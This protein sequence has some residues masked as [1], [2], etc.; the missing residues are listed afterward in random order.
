LIEFFQKMKL[1]PRAPRCQNGCQLND[2]MSTVDDGQPL[3]KPYLP[4]KSSVS[5]VTAI[6]G[7]ERQERAPRQREPAEISAAPKKNGKSFK[8]KTNTAR[9]LWTNRNRMPFSR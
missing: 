1:K 8:N 6:D 4:V 3:V 7:A 2:R 9:V 5:H